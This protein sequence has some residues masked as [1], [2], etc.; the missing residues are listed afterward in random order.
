MSPDERY[1]GAC[2]YFQA[3]QEWTGRERPGQCRRFAPQVAAGWPAVSE[4]DWC[5]EFDPADA[6]D[7]LTDGAVVTFRRR[8]A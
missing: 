4:A 8:R 2:A 1:C 3:D 5:G 6:D 7:G